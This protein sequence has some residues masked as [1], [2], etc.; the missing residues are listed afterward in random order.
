MIAWSRSDSS[1]LITR[2][3]PLANGHNPGMAELSLERAARNEVVFRDANETIEA[4]RGELTEIAGRTPFLCECADAYCKA[5]IPMTVDEYEFVR[6]Q[7]NRFALRPGHPTAEAT[8]VAE[9]ERY[10]VV[11]KGGLSRRIAE[12]TNP[13]A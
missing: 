3:I 7:A 10:V 6:E 13:R 8:V 4:R 1:P 12:E 11:E 9:T 2:I 5:A